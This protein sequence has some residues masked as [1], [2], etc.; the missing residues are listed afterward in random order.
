MKKRA[1][2]SAIFMNILGVTVLI[3]YLCVYM[4][5]MKSILAAEIIKKPM[6][7]FLI[8]AHKGMSGS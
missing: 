3:T 7:Y 6:W 1:V 5:V 2:Q 8:Y 4:Q